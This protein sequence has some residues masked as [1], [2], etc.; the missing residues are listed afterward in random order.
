MVARESDLI[1]KV[2]EEQ[3]DAEASAAA[4]AV[5]PAAI[6]HFCLPGEYVSNYERIKK[7]FEDQSGEDED[8]PPEEDE[9]HDVA[10]EEEEDEEE[11]RCL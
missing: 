11:V 8:V 9:D 1:Q 3:N 4:A 7:R 10:P 2:Q 5:A 6:T